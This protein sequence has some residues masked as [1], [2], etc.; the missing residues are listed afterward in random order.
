MFFA[1][2]GPPI[3]VDLGDGRMRL[4]S[5]GTGPA[6]LL[7]HGY[8]QTHAMWHAVAGQ[9]L[10]QGY[11]VI[12]PDLPGS[13]GSFPALANDAEAGTAAFMSRRLFALLDEI[14]VDTASLVGH[15]RGGRVAHRMALTEPARTSRLALL[16]IVPAPLPFERT[17]MAASLASY[18]MFWFA[19]AHPKPESLLHGAPGSWFA[20]TL[21]GGQAPAYFHPE[22]VADYLGPDPDPAAL[23]VRGETYRQALELDAAAER[24]GNADTGRVTCPTLV[25]WAARGMLGGW[26][27]PVALWQD[28][29]AAPLSGAAIDAGH[30]LAEEAPD[31]VAARLAA[32]LPSVAPG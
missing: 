21:P 26:Y 3:T 16:D 7:L 11:R 9:L 28:H 30:F 19:Q 8:P 12:C 17:D 4:R 32:F 18:R 24:S 29:V 6:V 1:G 5:A 31:A 25:L 20:G 22:A 15:D 13:G 14:G 10:E 23:A 27:D 2:F